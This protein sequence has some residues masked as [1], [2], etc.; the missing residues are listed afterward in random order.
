MISFDIVIPTIGRPCLGRLLDSLAASG[1]GV[2]PASLILVDDRRHPLPELP[3]A[4]GLAGTG[5]LPLVQVVGTG[6][7]GPAAAR[8]AG[9]RAGSAEWVVFLDDD[10]VTTPSWLADLVAD[11][12]EPPTTVAGSQGRLEVPLPA[13]RRPTDWERNVKGLERAQWATADMAYRRSA[14]S[15]VGG[16]DQRF[17]RAYREDADLGLRIIGAGYRIAS[18]KRRILHPVRPAG[19]WAS[20]RLQAGNADDALMARL[21]GSAW[22]VRAGVPRGRR[23]RHIALT[24]AGVVAVAGVLVRR[25]RL[26]CAGLLG[27]LAGTVEFAAARILPGPRTRKEVAT[28]VLTS[29]AVPPV[30]TAHWLAGVLRARRIASRKEAVR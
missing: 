14:L 27:W 5:I 12:S 30:A 24:A 15:E 7:Q 18:G 19:P 29:A 9:W 2:R 3:L 22:R 28:M 23:P 13:D 11:L 20:V 26:A 8:N 17:P 21:H 1:G 25:P 4:S 10:V 6:G 16:F